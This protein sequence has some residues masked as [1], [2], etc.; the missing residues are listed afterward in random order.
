MEELIE[1]ATRD[2]KILEEISFNGILVEN[3]GDKPYLKRVLDP[4]TLAAMTIIVRE[5]VKSISIPVGVNLLR[6]SGLE[7][8]SIATIAGGK[9]IRVNALVEVLLTNSE[10]IELEASR[11]RTIRLNYPGIEIFKDIVCKH[12]VSVTFTNL[13]A[14]YG[15]D[16]TLKTIVFDAIE[17]GG[18]DYIIV[19]GARTGEPP[20]PQLLEKIYRVS[21]VPIVIGSDTTPE[22]ICKLLSY[23]R[24]AIVGSYIK[25]G[26]RAGNPI[27]LE[28]AK[29]FI[30]AL[31]NYR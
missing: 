7:A 19:I 6:N 29:R 12:G 26:G 25:I 22:N 16:E 18:A 28:R 14:I 5:I 31:R 3:F 20:T 11:L 13:S 9:F 24:G 30:E 27:D 21:P 8:Y 4:L 23:A 2:A 10:I 15:V 17:R 1:R